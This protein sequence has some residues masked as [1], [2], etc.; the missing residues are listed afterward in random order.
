MALVLNSPILQPLHDELFVNKSVK[1]FVQRDDLIHPFIS[2]NKWRKLK[3]NIEEFRRQGKEYLLT[4]GGAYSNHIVATAAAG[5]EYGIKTIGVIRG[6][7][8][9]ELNDALTFAKANGMK[10]FFISRE[11]YRKK[12]GKHFL[13]SLLHHISSSLS[14][15]LRTPD[16]QLFYILPEGGSNAFAV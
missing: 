1:V 7:E 9:R 11:D 12:D 14:P 5:K 13:D 8:E 6:E 16:S 3:Y 4:F 2:G 10:L 15:E